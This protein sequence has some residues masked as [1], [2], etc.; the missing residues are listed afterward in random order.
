MTTYKY[1]S[2]GAVCLSFDSDDLRFGYSWDTTPVMCCLASESS[3]VP[4]LRCTGKWMKTLESLVKEMS[5][6]HL[7]AVGKTFSY[8]Q[9]HDFSI[10][11]IE[12]PHVT[13]CCA[14]CSNTDCIVNLTM[15]VVETMRLPLQLKPYTYRCGDYTYNVKE[16]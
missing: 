6:T 11:I 4:N 13:S 3:Y 7:Y 9:T 16:I 12:K 10:S 1:P 15:T 2:V 5:I 8:L 14:D